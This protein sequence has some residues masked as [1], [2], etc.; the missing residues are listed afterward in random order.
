MVCISSPIAATAVP[1]LRAHARIRYKAVDAPARFLSAGGGNAV[2]T[3]TACRAVS[4]Q[5]R[6]PPRVHCCRHC[7]AFP[8]NRP[9]HAINVLRL[10]SVTPGG[11]A[12]VAPA[13][14]G[15]TRNPTDSQFDSHG[16][17]HGR[18]R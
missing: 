4:A 10:R 8:S 13:K 2:L 7:V 16:V 18:M 9:A 6:G 15:R 11:R 14:G 1:C 3:T 17:E 5:Q 12:H